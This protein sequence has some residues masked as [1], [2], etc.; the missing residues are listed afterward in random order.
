MLSGLFLSQII[1]QCQAILVDDE[2][3]LIADLS[4]SNPY[5]PDAQ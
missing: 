4:Y 1:E 5:I 3:L 2:L